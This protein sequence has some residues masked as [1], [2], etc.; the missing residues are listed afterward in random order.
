MFY[1]LSI[2]MRKQLALQQHS[3]QADDNSINTN[4]C[5]LFYMHSYSGLGYLYS[6]KYLISASY[7]AMIWF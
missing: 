6:I 1:S 7:I 2:D 5:L 3:T 4:M